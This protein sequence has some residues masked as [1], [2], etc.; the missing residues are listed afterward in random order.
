MPLS[1]TFRYTTIQRSIRLFWGRMIGRRTPFIS[2]TRRPTTNLSRMSDQRMQ[3]GRTNTRDKRVAKYR[4]R[5]SFSSYV[6]A[7]TTYRLTPCAVSLVN[8]NR[9]RL[10]RGK[11]PPIHFRIRCVAATRRFIKLSDH[12]CVLTERGVRERL[13]GARPFHIRY[14]SRN[15]APRVDGVS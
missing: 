2:P 8:F 9:T 13:L 11:I 14:F 5:K 3:R 10:H 1:R 7:V 4:A 15:G 6:P 12:F